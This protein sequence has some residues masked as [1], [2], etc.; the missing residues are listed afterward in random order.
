MPDILHRISIDAPSKQVHDV[1]ASADGIARWWTGRPLAGEHSIGSSFSYAPGPTAA[2]R[3][4][5]AT[6]TGGKPVSS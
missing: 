5:S 1:I 3:F 6:P 2:P 4:C